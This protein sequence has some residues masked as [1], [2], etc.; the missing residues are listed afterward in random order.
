M[1]EVSGNG[2]WSGGIGPL[3]HFGLGDATNVDLVRIE[4]P[5]GI[6][7]ELR[8]VPANQVLTV[9]EPA[10]LEMTQPGELRIQC[11]RGQA[12]D[13]EAS[14]DLSTWTRIGSV[15]NTTGVLT[16]TDPDGA[17]SPDRFYRV[18]GK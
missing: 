17:Q 15:T 4:W 8:N 1:R 13:L 7:Q 2:A 12:F 14:N 6:V 11:W 3:A 16:W 10:R 9:T 5:S 18:L